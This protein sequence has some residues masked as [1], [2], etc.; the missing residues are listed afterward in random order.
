MLIPLNINL[1]NIILIPFIVYYAKELVI[2]DFN[3]F[4]VYL[5]KIK[6]SENNLNRTAFA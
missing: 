4:Q 2:L 6:Q 1:L 5:S 3:H